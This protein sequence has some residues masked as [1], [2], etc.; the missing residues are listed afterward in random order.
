MLNNR[1]YPNYQSHPA[2][3]VAQEFRTYL[4]RVLVHPIEILK[5]YITTRRIIHS[6]QAYHL[7]LMQLEH[8]SAFLMHSPFTSMPEF[9]RCVI[10]AFAAGA[11]RHH[12]LVF[13]AH[14]LES[15]RRALER[16]VAALAAHYKIADCFDYVPGGKLAQLLDHAVT[17]NSTAGQQALWRRSGN[18]Q[19]ICK[20]GSS[21]VAFRSIIPPYP[22]RWHCPLAIEFWCL[23]KWKMTR[24]FD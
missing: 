21:L 24:Q 14:P 12:R 22:R 2:D 4:R 20:I 23:R 17:V 5:R 7:V 16:D 1:A 13:K 8:D 19:P 9:L 15:G 10:K 18:A 3:R 11:P 6:G